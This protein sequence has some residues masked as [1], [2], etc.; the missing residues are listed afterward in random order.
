VRGLLYGDFSQ[1]FMQVI[2]AAVVIV[3]GFV[4]AYVWFKISNLLTPLRV[5]RETEVEGPRRSKKWAYWDTR[6]FSSIPSLR[7]ANHEI[8]K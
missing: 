7:A 1:F 6:T 5:S 2:N 4:M 3:F 8:T